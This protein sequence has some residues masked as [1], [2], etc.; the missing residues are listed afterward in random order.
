MIRICVAL[1]FIDMYTILF[2][3]VLVL[4]YFY[5]LCILYILLDVVAWV[6]AEL[7]FTLLGSKLEYAS[8]V[9]NCITPTDANKLERIQQK[10]ASVRF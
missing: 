4:F 8:A 5:I 6:E 9:W 10:F 1:V 7:N 2:I 3:C